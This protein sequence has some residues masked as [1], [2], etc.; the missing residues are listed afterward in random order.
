MQSQA[1]QK[2]IP[3]NFPGIPPFPDDVSTAP[4][5]RLSSGKLLVGDHAE[6]ER[7]FQASTDI[8]FFYLDLSDSKQGSSL[9]S[10][11]DNLF[12]VGERLFELSI[13]EKMQYDFSAQN[14]YFGYKAQGAA[15]VDKQG[16]LDRNE[17][18]N[19]SKDDILGI[20][21]PLQA[22]E[23]LHKSRARLESFIRGSHA[24]VTLILNILNGQLTLPKDT[25]S[26]LH[27]QYAVS[28]NQVRFVKAPP[29][30]VD[31]R[32]TAMGQHTDFGSVTVLFNRLGGLQVLPPG[33]DAEWVYVRP[34]PGHAIINLG[35]AMVKFTNGLF[36]SN[37]HRVVAP[38][39]LQAES[40]RYSLVYFARPEDSVMLR[41]LEGSDR[42][43]VMEDGQTDEEINSKD[44]ILRRGLGRRVD[45]VK[46]VDFEMS[47]GT[48]QVSRRIMV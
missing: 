14:S 47:A 44:W 30:P 2:D 28:G 19:V 39:G 23:I 5:L 26:N 33:A 8:G 22:P 37:I 7:L 12:Q 11:A 31:D 43:P 42:I 10:D 35:D 13:E 16:N 4:L 29:Q 46:D 9:L 32:R 40:T 20:S 25:L 38:P 48:E 17:F 45:R 27:R 18:Y 15:V 1:N 36:R 6:H 21:D 41:R 3:N 24:I 34:L